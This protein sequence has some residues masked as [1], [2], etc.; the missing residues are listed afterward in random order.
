MSVEFTKYAVAVKHKATGA[1]SYLRDSHTVPDLADADLKSKWAAEGFANH[2]LYTANHLLYT[3]DPRDY[4]LEA[5]PV[6]CKAA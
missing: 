6:T 2:L 4:S 5:I 3:F 1:V